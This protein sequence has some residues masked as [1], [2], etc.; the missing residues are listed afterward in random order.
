MPYVDKLYDTNFLE[1]ASYV[2]KERAIPDVEDGLKPV[3]RR[4]LHT[5]FEMDDGKFHKVANVVG[6]TMKYHPHGDLSIVGALILLA[7]KDLFIE[8]QGN[9]G[10]IFT[11]D[12]AS[13]ARY[14]E[15]RLTPLARDVLYNPEITEFV[16]SYDGR[17]REPVAF[18][19][20]IPVL[21]V[22]G[23]EGIAVGMSTRIL[24]HNFVEVLQAQIAYL[25]GRK[26]K[27]YPDFPTGGQIDVSEYN[28][29]NGKVLVRAV[30]DN[31]DS[32][33]I[34]VRQLPFGF[35]SESLISSIEDAAK[36]GKLKVSSIADYTTEDVEIEIHLARGVHSKD[37]LDALFAFTGCENSITT[38]MMVIKDD[39][40]HIMSV[41]EIVKHCTDQLVEILKVELKIEQGKLN[42]RLHAKTLE[43]IFIENRIY[44]EIE[45]Q[46]TAEAVRQAVHDG[47]KPYKKKI[48]REVTEE[49]IE[50]L[51]RIPIRRISLYDI[52]KAQEEM[53]E[54]RKRLRQVLRHLKEI[55]AYAISYLEDLIKKYGDLYPRRT[56]VVEFEK[57]DARE[58][59]QRNLTLKYDKNTG[60]LGHQVNGATIMDVSVYDRVLVIR[61]SG[62]YSVIDAPDRLFVDKGMLFCGFVDEDRVYT[63]VY[64]DP[65]GYPCLKRCTISKFILN[66]GYDLVPQGSRVLKLTT[67]SNQGVVVKYK[68]KARVRILEEEFHVEEF[69]VRGNKA[70]GYRLASREAQSA[71][72]FALE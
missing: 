39:H 31:K 60:Y 46:E 59:A 36:K 15:C 28:D 68:P 25:K 29:G 23:T 1:Y 67:E 70:K 5:L 4:I 7:N 50:T 48:R 52:N 54:I 13:A 17:N 56:E 3:Q 44:K 12:E 26:F 34:V 41:T 69:T 65:K 33:R 27:L 11:G 47:L 42:D 30:L 55:K 2:I 37:T 64:K 53:V 62:T 8:K 38:S 72:F 58:A 43:Q 57:V 40:P 21:L 32:K 18:P 24:P 66:R 71:S 45:E 16:D 63:L 19:A 22:Q 10:N 35:T 9:F 61:K 6:S 51:L 49:D 14:I 20:K